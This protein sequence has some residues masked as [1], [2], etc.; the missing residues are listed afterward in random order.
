M[1]TNHTT[2]R[3]PHKEHKTIGGILLSGLDVEETIANGV[4]KDYMDRKNWPVELKDETFEEIRGYLKVLIDDTA[5]HKN[6]ITY[7]ISKMES[8]HE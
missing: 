5:R 2:E 3:P 1:P 6:I 4:Y 7:L 8:S